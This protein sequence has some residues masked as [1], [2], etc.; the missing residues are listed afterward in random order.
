MTRLTLDELAVLTLTDDWRAV[1]SAALDAVDDS[2]G[3]AVRGTVRGA[4]WDVAE[5]T[6]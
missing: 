5:E 2:V 1:R 6:R 3:E 4:V